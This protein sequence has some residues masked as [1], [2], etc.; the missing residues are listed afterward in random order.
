MH[1]HSIHDGWL[2]FTVGK[3]SFI[4]SYLTD[5]V[6]DVTKAL[7]LLPKEGSSEVMLDGEGVDLKLTFRLNPN[8]P[9]AVSVT[10]EKFSSPDDV[11]VVEIQIEGTYQ[12]L[13][14]KWRE[15]CTEIEYEYKQD[16]LMFN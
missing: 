1:I 9:G 15:L 3:L 5:V 14:D 13:L 6:G 8:I 16:F 7:E 4:A 2:T 12:E 11:E 10:W